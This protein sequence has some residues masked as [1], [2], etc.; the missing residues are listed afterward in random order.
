MIEQLSQVVN[1]SSDGKISE[2]LTEKFLRLFPSWQIIIA[3][4]IALGILLIVFTKLVW[5]PV[6]K[7]HKER[8]NYIQE[9]IDSAIKQNED[10][11]K[12]VS[13]SQ[14]QLREAKMKSADL[15][16]EAKEEAQYLKSMK[17][18]EIRKQTERMFRKAE[19]NIEQEKIQFENQKKESIIEIALSAA[20]K[21][22]EK[23]IDNSVS[24]KIIEDYLKSK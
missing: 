16:N 9:N 21:V 14:E 20:S 6:K 24:E 10:A 11:A 17:V 12:S 4:L 1:Y 3:T 8:V 23:E 7:M 2:D 18:E 15:I 5:K 22:V 13:A 19:E